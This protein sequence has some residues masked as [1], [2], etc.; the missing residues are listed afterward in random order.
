M[1]HMISQR[2]KGLREQHGLSQPEL[3]KKL[4]VSRTSVSG[5]EQ[6]VNCPN[7]ACLIE[8]SRLFHTTVDYILD[9]DSSL[10]L[11]LDSFSDKEK[12]VLFS[13]I[14]YFDEARETSGLN[15]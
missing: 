7:A 11:K 14:Q 3:A 4:G 5:W 10:V 12:T 8:M 15:K 6:G 13:L 1:I 9:I 2:I